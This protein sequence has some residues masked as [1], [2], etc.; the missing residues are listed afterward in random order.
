MLTSTTRLRLQA[1][2]ERIGNDQPVSLG[3]R[4]Y[5]QK[6]ADR[7]QAVAGWLWRARNHQ[8]VG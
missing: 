1:I 3:E 4:I 7:D 5:L 8:M 6:F 2:I